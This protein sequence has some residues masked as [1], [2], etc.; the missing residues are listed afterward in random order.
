MKEFLTYQ[1]QLIDFEYGGTN[2]VAFDMTNHF[3][4][5]AGGTT[6]EE[7]GVPD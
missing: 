6:K 4:E 7:S 2:Y 3:N 1:I 5:H